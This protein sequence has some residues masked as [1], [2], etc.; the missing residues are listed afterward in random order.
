MDNAL[1]WVRKGWNLS[2]ENKKCT[3]MR[4]KLKKSLWKSQWSLRKGSVQSSES[5][6]ELIDLKRTAALIYA[7]SVAE[8]VFF[9]GRG[10]GGK[11]NNSKISTFKKLILELNCCSFLIISHFYWLS[12]HFEKFVGGLEL[13]WGRGA[14]PT[15]VPLS[16]A[17]AQ[18]ANT[19]SHFRFLSVTLMTK[20]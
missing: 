4:L 17:T 6:F 15:L 9:L 13:F 10:G 1:V 2:D 11:K 16:S 20:S 19:C 3:E 8:P 7:I 18:Y 12:V 14:W 5:D